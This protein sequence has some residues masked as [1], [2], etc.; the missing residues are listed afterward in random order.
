MARGRADIAN[1]AIRILLQNVGKYY[2]EIRGLVPFSPTGPQRKV[3]LEFFDHKCV[4]CAI[5][6]EKNQTDWDH[7]IPINKTDLG[8]HA[9]GNVVPCCTPCHKKKHH[10]NWED[11]TKNIRLRNKILAFQKKYEYRPKLDL[12]TVADT[13]YE[14][15]GA[16]AMTLIE[17][18]FKQ[19]QK[20]LKSLKS[21]K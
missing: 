3:V 18:R 17:L 20:T 8:L 16:V 6:L 21:K 12:G 2:D 15:V 5:L 4:F 19:A 7:L 10:G 13:L 1:M 14:D 11:A 9:W